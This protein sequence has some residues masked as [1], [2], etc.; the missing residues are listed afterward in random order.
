MTAT[1][2]K[3]V[4]P[5]DN[6]IMYAIS[7]LLPSLFSDEEGNTLYPDLDLLLLSKCGNRLIT[8]IV[9]MLLDTSGTLPS[10]SISRLAALI[11]SEYGEAW[12]RINTALTV[13]Y[14]PLYNGTYHEE[15]KQETEGET[16]DSTNETSNND[17]S[18]F[19]TSPGNYVTDG[20]TTSESKATG[21]NKSAMK[22]TLDR[23]S[24]GANYRSS[25]LLQS[26][27][28][29]RVNTRFTSQVIQ[30]VKNYIAMQIY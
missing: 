23:T 28:D 15:I 14:N 18:A 8:P 7:G 20:K 26:E 24:M 29:M 21:T 10:A 4:F 12:E 11:V 19:N 25:D 27:I 22:R 2:V 6:G 16:G 13:E 1:K 9:D 3:S 17:V 30:D 5:I